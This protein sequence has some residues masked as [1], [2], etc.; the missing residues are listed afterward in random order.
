ME[1]EDIDKWLLTSL[2]SVLQECEEHYRNYETSKVRR[3][4]EEFFL[5]I[6][7]DN[8]LEMVKHRLYNPDEYGEES[9]QAAIHTLYKGLLASLKVFTPIIP[10]ITEEIYQNLFGSKEKS[11]SINKSDWPE[12]DE[13]LLDEE[14]KEKGELAKDII[15]EI[16]R[17]KSD[18]GIPLNEDV[19]MVQFYADSEA[20]K[21]IDEMREV[22]QGT[23]NVEDISY[24]RPVDSGEGIKVED[25][26]VE[27]KKIEAE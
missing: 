21:K 9:K 1:L 2:E 4:M 27:I 10:H 18:E 22:I 12:V 23:I 3:K 14:A 24:Q 6:F 8:Y 7:C 19:P 5:E 11:K 15:E 20:R 17:W 16:R 26:Q 13:E 25:Q